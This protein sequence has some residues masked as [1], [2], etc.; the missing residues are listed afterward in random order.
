MNLPAGIFHTGFCIALARYHAC[1]GVRAADLADKDFHLRRAD[2]F[3]D[4]AALPPSQMRLV[5]NLSE[6]FPQFGLVRCRFSGAL[7]KRPPVVVAGG[8]FTL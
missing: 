3:I 7:H 5:L 4:C 1:I 2:A 8:R 6:R